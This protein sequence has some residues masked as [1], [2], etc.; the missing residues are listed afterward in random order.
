MKKISLAWQIFIGLILGIIVGAVFYGNPHVDQILTPFGAIFLRLI[1][2]IVV[3]IVISCLVVGVAGAG[4]MKSLGKLGGK[5]L[6]YFEIITTIAIVVGLLVANMVHPGTGVDR[7]QLVKSDMTAY[8]TTE[9]TTE[10]HS[11]I[12]TFV[13][14]VPTNVVQAFANGDMLSIIFFSVMFGLGVAAIGEKGEPILKFFRGTADA[15]FYVTN[16][17]MKVAPIG[18]FA[19]IGVTVSKF[20]LSSLIPLGKLVVTVYGAMI[21]FV[22]VVLGIVAKIAGYNIFKLLGYLKDELILG[23]STASSE[24]VL[25]RIMEKMERIGCP[26]GITS[27]VIPTGYSFNL[28]GSTLY[29]AIAALFIAQ[30]YGIHLSIGH[31]ITLVLILMVTSKG[32][33]GVPGVSIVVLLSTLGSV[34]IP[35][36]GLAFILGVDRLLDMARTA[37]NVVGNSLA[38]IVISKWEGHKLKDRPEKLAA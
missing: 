20:G 36:E 14:I 34:G 25:P 10:S 12:D 9:K 27:F 17:I 30:M 31:Q 16:Q 4:D 28:D 19:L 38:A 35:V 1:K 6:I 7:S 23:Y 37:V 2:M 3:P 13:N 32:I 5:T 26:K 21:F 11:K 15:M 18:V 29:Q 24:T 33:A 8:V 22:I